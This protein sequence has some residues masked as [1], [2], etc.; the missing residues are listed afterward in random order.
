MAN[1]DHVQQVLRCV[2]DPKYTWERSVFTGLDLTGADLRVCMLQG[3]NFVNCDFSDANL[4]DVSMGFSLFQSCKFNHAD[5]RQTHPGSSRFYGGSFKGTNLERAYMAEGIFIGADFTGAN[6]VGV[7]AAWA[8]F[9]RCIFDNA[10]MRKMILQNCEMPQAS[11]RGAQLHEA[12]LMNTV[13]SGVNLTGATGLDAMRFSAPS[14][15]DSEA[16][17]LSGSLPLAFLRGCGLAD[18]VIEFYES[19]SGAIQFN[20]CFISFAEADRNFTDRLYA[21]LQARGVRCYYVPESGRTGERLRGSLMGA[22]QMHE[23]LLV[24]LSATSIT[25]PWVESEVEAAFE[26]ER[27]ERRDM[28]FPIRIDDSVMATKQAWA[29]EIRRTRRIGDFTNWQEPTNYASNLDRLI[30]DL[31]KR[32]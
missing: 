27:N 32:G 18:E 3:F 29:E 31:R 19:L 8:N 28:L 6:L 1:A 4:N 5:M 9:R 14:A 15:F 22:I 25:R 11:L 17:E 10:N 24:V 30:D 2:R 16:A 23:K 26:R 7:T 20:S 21:D 12:E 13:L